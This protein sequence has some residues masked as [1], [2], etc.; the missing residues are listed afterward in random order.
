MIEKSKLHR[1]WWRAT[2]FKWSTCSTRWETRMSLVEARGLSFTYKSS[3]QR[4]IHD[5]SLSIAPGEFVSVQGPSGSGKST[6]LYL[7]A[8]F[9]K[10]SSG[11]IFFDGQD[12]QSLDAEDTAIFRNRHMGFIFQQFHLMGRK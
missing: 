9:L 7:L 5:L 1:E 12:L 3:T 11:Q 4:I 2:S 10:P 8:G 6:L